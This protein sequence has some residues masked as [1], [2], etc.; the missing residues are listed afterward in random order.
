MSERRHPE[1][2]LVLA[3]PGRP[4]GKVRD[5]TRVRGNVGYDDPLFQKETIGA[6]I[7]RRAALPSLNPPSS[8]SRV[9][10]RVRRPS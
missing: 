4:V 5:T 3:R 8:H 6:L 10:G 7:V 2:V 1:D 9:R